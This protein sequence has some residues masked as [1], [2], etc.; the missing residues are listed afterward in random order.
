[1]KR[2]A[3]LCGAAV[4]V[5]APFGSSGQEI[6]WNNAPHKGFVFQINNKE[7]QHLLTRAPHDTIFRRL[8]HT[9]VDTFD[10]R[11]GWQQRPEQGHFILA[12]IVANQLHCEYISVFPYQV[13]LLQEYESLAL[14]VLD[15]EGN[16]RGDAAVKIKNRKI[17]IDTVSKTY[18]LANEWFGGTERYVTVEL[19]G[20]RSVFNVTRHKVPNWERNRYYGGDNDGPDFYSYMIT[21]KNKYKPGERVR[22]KSFALNGNRFLLR[23]PLELW[24]S[25]HGYKKLGTF[26]PHRPG[27]Y[28]GEFYLHDSLKIKLD[29]TYNLQLREKRGRVVANCRFK[30][31]DYELNGDQLEI[32]LAAEA[33]YHPVKNELT[34]LATDANGLTLKD[35]RATVIVRSENIRETFEPVVTLKDTLLRREIDLDPQEAT[36][37]G[38][39]SELF[40]KTNTSYEVIVRVLNS[41]NKAIEKTLSATH[42]YEARELKA[43]F[44]NDS[45]LYE[46]FITG[47]LV[48]DVPFLMR[49]DDEVVPRHVTLPYREKINAAVRKVD[50][51]GD[52]LS[53]QIEMRTVLPKVEIIGGIRRDSLNLQLVNPQQLDI[54]WFVYRG[55]ELQRKGFGKQMKFD[56]LITD[57]TYTYY[58]ELLFAFGGEDRMVRK[59]FRFMKNQLNIDLAISDRVYPG[60]QAEALIEVTDGSG[61]PVS[62]VDLT[63]VGVNGKL[64]HFL[65]NLPSYGSASYPRSQKATFSKED[66]NRKIVRLDLDYKKW[67]R[68]AGLDTM[69]YYNFTYPGKS[70]FSHTV[71][72]DDSTQFAAFVMQDGMAVKVHVV[73]VDH[74]PVY[75]DWVDQPREYS[76]YV[77]AYRKVSVSLRLHNRV[78]ILDS[79]AFKPGHKTI[80]SLDLDHLPENVTVIKIPANP[81][82][83]RWEPAT[84][85]LT[86]VEVNRHAN[87]ISTFRYRSETAYLEQ[88]KRIVPLF[89]VGDY[90]SRSIT[91]GPV[92]VG[93]YTFS[94]PAEKLSTTYLHEGRYD[95]QVEGNVVYKLTGYGMMPKVLRKYSFDPMK[96]INDKVMTKEE[97]KKPRTKL[98]EWHTR[99]VTLVDHSVMMKIHLPE[100]KAKSGL[101]NLLFV[102]CVNNTVI[103]P[104]RYMSGSRSELHNIPSGCYNVVVLF[105]NG[106]YLKMDRIDIQRWSKIVIDLNH[107]PLMQADSASK[108]WSLKAAVDCIPKEERRVIHMRAPSPNSSANV[109][110]RVTA[111]EDGSGLPGVNVLVRGTTNGTVTDA[112][113]YYALYINGEATLDFSFIG[114]STQSV[115]VGERSVV[116][117][118]MTPDIMQLTEVIVTGQGIMHDKRALGYSVISDDFSETYFQDSEETETGR[119][120]AEQA[121]YNELLHL[122][123]IRSNFSDVAFWEPKLYTDRKGQSRFMVTFPD[124]ITRW[125]ATV[126][127]M[128]RRLQT[129]TGRRTIKSY[130]PIMAELHVTNFLTQGDSAVFLG[131]VLNYTDDQLIKGK[132]AFESLRDSTNLNKEIEFSE[133]HLDRLPV[134]AAST[135]SIKSRYVFTRDD[136]YIDGEERKVAVVPQGIVRSDGALTVLHNNEEI[137]LKAKPDEELMVE[138]LATPI[139]V[140]AG[141]ARSLMS[142]RFECNEQLASKLTGLLTYRQLMAYEHKPFRYDKEVNHIIGRLLRNQNEEFL[143]SW[144]NV[145]SNTSFWMSAHV[146]R[147]LRNASDAGYVVN[148]DVS[149]VTRKVQYKFEFLK[150]FSRHDADLLNALSKWNA[151]LDYAKYI[152]RIEA[153]MENRRKIQ[154]TSYRGSYTLSDYGFLDEAL[155][156]QEIRLERGLNYRRDSLMRYQRKG[157]LGEVY[158]SSGFERAY[159]HYDDKIKVNS[160]A[161][162][163]IKKDPALQHLL[164]PMQLYFLHERDKQNWNTYQAS[165]ILMSVFADLVASGASKEHVTSVQLSGKTNAA[166]TAFPYQVALQPGEELR[167]RK[168]S[169]IPM[170]VM[171]YRKERTT[172]AKTGVEGFEIKTTLAGNA[173]VLEA[174]Q[175]VTM[176]VEVKVS[177]DA[178]R[179]YVMIEI[180]IPASCSYAEKSQFRGAVETHREYFKERTVIFCQQMRAGTYTFDAK[181]LPRFTGNYV[182]NPAQVSLMYYPVIN[183]NT[184]MRRVSVR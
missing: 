163:I 124:D 23:K 40:G 158:F 137:V 31:E 112:D 106:T 81:K 30:Y 20:F 35:A 37:F 55:N 19:E 166:V 28:A 100:E 5:F 144:W 89:R 128:N 94:V 41:Q 174:G 71:A 143:W 153:A 182:V 77:P 45:I 120:D 39:P 145:S 1:M 52:S 134:Y 176:N 51:R 27:S 82:E 150:E 146:L 53:T 177:K 83:R 132:V 49:Y 4:I 90:I 64:G 172:V 181:L 111:I 142:Y 101:N 63:A 164:V 44:S 38:I 12:T 108:L 13:F 180:P 74:V 75:F 102:H 91:V 57:R 154:A 123:T 161:Y 68:R 60:Q 29:Q 67:A 151:N 84:W 173:H 18:R 178:I 105:N 62:G 88:G 113:G 170:Y 114:F 110:G 148:L 96:V 160:T 130:K 138:L 34:I 171:S 122:S 149:N 22:F 58:V 21:D 56:T 80:L 156:L 99:L 179:E 135:D 59:E 119:Q 184:A 131:K 47:S 73:E 157:L 14:Q 15:K 162:R 17:R 8:L 3:L 10:A 24:L 86:D 183:A 117:V 61:F 141:E 2:L 121:L 152:A 50:F 116:D 155:L 98:D 72:I 42:F 70:M 66:V 65:P 125:E 93:A 6:R 127:A 165:N 159:W 129:G 147:A 168:T 133:F 103:S 43:R 79:I 33:H 97:F 87:Y 36:V 16:V 78:L 139:E 46:Y 109:F 107:A 92:P 26:E 118:G 115:E 126:Y 9:Q 85:S 140:F 136:G 54:S 69:L 25:G 76:F 175:P 7:A 48:K 104:C 169:G 167:V 11:Q 32:R 95:Y